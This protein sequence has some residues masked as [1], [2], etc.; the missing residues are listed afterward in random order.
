M[1]ALGD[2]Q[3]S[4]L[5]AHMDDDEVREVA[6]TMANLG[7]ISS[8]VIERLFLDFAEQMSSTGSLVSTRTACSRTWTASVSRAATS[9][10]PCMSPKWR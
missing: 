5:F 2:E 4:R 1:L 7:M 9:S 3:A 8:T 6:Q 10:S